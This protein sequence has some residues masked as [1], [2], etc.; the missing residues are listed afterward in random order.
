MGI[1]MYLLS[2]LLSLEEIKQLARLSHPKVIVD[3]SG[4]CPQATELANVLAERIG[5][6]DAKTLQ[7]FI[8]EI[9]SRLSAIKDSTP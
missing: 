9:N 7:W 6:L 1:I 5:E 4:L 2:A 8:N 3:T